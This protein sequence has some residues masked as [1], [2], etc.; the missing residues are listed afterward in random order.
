MIV[1]R[2]DQFSVD[3]VA[4]DKQIM[5]QTDLPHSLKTLSIKYGSGGVIRSVEN[6]RLRFFRNKTL[7][8]IFPYLESGCAG[9]ELDRNGPAELDDFLVQNKRGRGDYHLIARIENTQQR[10]EQSLCS[11]GGNYDLAFSTFKAVF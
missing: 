3:I 1:I 5:L 4:N 6:N 9:I 8:T 10:Y 2:V 7:K 11:T